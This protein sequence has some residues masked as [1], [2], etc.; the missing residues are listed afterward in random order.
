MPFPLIFARTLRA[1]G[2]CALGVCALGFLSACGGG[3][4]GVNVESEGGG[5]IP[6]PA[7]A[8]FSV[9]VVARNT[10]CAFNGC[11]ARAAKHSADGEFKNIGD[12]HNPLDRINADFAYARGFT[13]KGVTVA[14]ADHGINMDHPEFAG[15]ITLG[16]NA[17]NL[18][19]TPEDDSGHG[20]AVAGIIAAAKNNS[21]TVGA[22]MHGVAYDAT[23]IPVRILEINPN[24]NTDI[25]KPSKNPHSC[26]PIDSRRRAAGIQHGIDNAFVINN[27]WG[28]R[29]FT[30]IQGV[31][32][33]R[34]ED[35]VEKDVRQAFLSAADPDKD[36]VIVFA[37]GND[38]WNTETGK[39]LDAGVKDRRLDLSVSANLPGEW[40]MTPAKFPELQGHWLHVVA[41][42]RNDNI[43]YFSNGCG[44]AQAW[45]LAAP[46][47]NIR[48]P[49]TMF[50]G[51][52]NGRRVDEGT[53]YAA[54]MVSGAAAI[55]KS[56]FPNLSARQV[57]T[58]LL[59]TANKEGRFS[60]SDVYGQGMLDLEKATRPQT[61][62]TCGEDGYDCPRRRPVSGLRLATAQN[63]G[64]DGLEI[65]DFAFADLADS[66]IHPSPVFGDAFSRSNAAAGFVDAF[67][68]AYQTRISGLSGAPTAARGDPA[69]AMREDAGMRTRTLADGFFARETRGGLPAEFGW[70]ARRGDFSAALTEARNWRAGNAAGAW[71]AAFALGA[72]RWRGVELAAGA[73]RAGFRAAEF[74]ATDAL[75]RQWFLARD[76][77]GGG[78]S[79]SPEAGVF[80]EDGSV[81]GAGFAGGFAAQGARTFYGK[82]NGAANLGF[83][84]R[85]FAGALLARTSAENGR[86]SARFSNLRSGGWQAGLGG[87]RWQFSF[88]RPAG[89]LSGQM[90]IAGVAGY[91]QSGK[92]RAAESRVDLS[93]G[94][95]R[96]LTFAASD[97]KGDV[98]W[99]AEKELGGAARFSVS[100]GR[101][102]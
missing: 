56:A 5:N 84:L 26:D 58:L 23:I 8:K 99:S 33:R 15:R 63:G 17:G 27:S 14:V 66:R 98:W 21:S 10:D 55:L 102:F 37:T 32:V 16:Y 67:D 94:H 97:A 73:V 30:V 20:T 86:H 7:V 82:V 38:G 19:K 42:D 85:G 3:G 52:S 44:A 41:L 4:S 18:S 74:S 79:V 47:T 76:F 87:Q 91:D 22:G 28:G 92:Y 81:L 90:R 40:G 59:M 31:H 51:D 93:A 77:A 35:R 9:S 96:R 39:V 1:L 101:T 69:Q 24:R 83:G 48:A 43:A 49:D 54:P 65:H 100:G 68:R 80:D 88:W 11:A 46:G 72:S 78:W 60:N 95:A 50:F 71:D 61:H 6:A 13:G 75:L 29:A 57:V 45:C 89:V 34:P 70:R 64:G 53:S 12:N 62:A 25:C 2:F 36:R